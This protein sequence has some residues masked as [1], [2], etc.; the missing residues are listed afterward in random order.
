MG[1]SD[2]G[3]TGSA[4]FRLLPGER[5]VLTKTDQTDALRRLSRIRLQSI[6]SIQGSG[7]GDQNLARGRKLRARRAGDYLFHGRLDRS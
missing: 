2:L 6:L 3:A 4:A 1:V 5:A 7:H